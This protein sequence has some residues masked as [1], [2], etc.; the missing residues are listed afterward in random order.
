MGLR[1]WP[2]KNVLYDGAWQLRITAGH[3]SKRLNSLAV[4]DRSDIADMEIRLEKAKRHYAA[5]GRPLLIRETPLTPPEIGAYLVAEGAEAFDES[6]VMTLDLNEFQTA[7]AVEL[8][9]S[10]DVGRFVDASLAINPVEGLTKAGLAEVVTA[11]KPAHGLFIREDDKPYA[12]GLTV[13]DF[14]MAGIEAFAVAE[15]ARRQG[16]GRKLAAAML[17]WAKGRGAHMAWLQVTAQNTAGIAL[18][19]SLGFTEAYRYRYWRE[20][21]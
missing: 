14:D 3:P 21:Q 4:L 1:A 17:R 12:V 11:I 20:Q 10:Q 8:L 15:D 19:Q 2:A 18:Y 7:D 9:P 13:H 5:F 16:H 6:V